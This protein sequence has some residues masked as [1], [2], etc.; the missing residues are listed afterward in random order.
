MKNFVDK[1]IM[2]FSGALAFIA[3]LLW[4]TESHTVNPSFQLTMDALFV[5]GLIA[6]ATLVVLVKMKQKKEGLAL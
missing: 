6:F 1:F 5:P 4:I 3:G 2:I